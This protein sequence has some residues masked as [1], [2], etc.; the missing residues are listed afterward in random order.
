[1]EDS[2]VL[3]R[4]KR[5]REEDE[6]NL[7]ISTTE[8]ES[9]PKKQKKSDSSENNIQSSLYLESIVTKENNNNIH[10]NP[11]FIGE[12]K[13]TSNSPQDPKAKNSKQRKHIEIKKEEEV[14][15]F[16]GG[17]DGGFA[18]G[19]Q[20]LMDRIQKNKN[21]QEEPRKKKN[22]KI[23]SIG[24]AEDGEDLASHCSQG[25]NHDV[26]DILQRWDSLVSK[27]QWPMFEEMVKELVDKKVESEA[28]FSKA[29][30]SLQR[31]F[32]LLPKKAQL[33]HV[34][35]FMEQNG[36][37]PKNSQ[38][39]KLLI[40]KSGKSHSGVLVITVLTSPYPKVGDTVQ[41]FSCQW[42][43]YYCP[44]EPAHE[45]NNWTRQ[46]RSYLHDEPSVLRANRN[47]F[48]PVLQ[49]YD[50]AATLAMNGHPVD[51]IELLI[52]GGTW[53][54][55]PHQ[56]QEE[57]IRDL[58]YSAN[59]F[60]TREKR[61]K[62]SLDQEKKLNESA[63]CKIIGITLETRPDTITLEE[64]KR[65]RRYGCTR[66]QLGIQHTD[67][68]ILKKINRGCTL[69]DAIRAIRLLKNNCYKID[70]HLM[71]NLP[72]SSPE[73]DLEMFNYIL[74]SEDLQVDQ[75]KIYPC[76]ITPWT[77][78][79]KWYQSG[80]YV[81]YSD[82][83]L[84][85]LLLKVKKKVHPWIRLNRVIRDIP[86]QYILGGIDAP[87]LRQYL[88]ETLKKQGTPCRCI[89]CREVR[90]KEVTQVEMFVRT[91]HSSNGIEHFISFE[92]P[93]ETTIL[94]FLRLRFCKN[95]D[96]DTF[97]ELR[98]AALIRELHVYG[99]L[100]P[101]K[102]QQDSHAQHVG[103]GKRLMEKAETMAKENGCEKIAVIAGVGV[104]NYYRKLGYE[105]YGE[106]EFLIKKFK[107]PSKPPELSSKTFQLVEI[108]FFI[109][110]LFIFLASFLVLY[111]FS[112]SYLF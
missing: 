28:Q 39:R 30:L 25:Y 42:N 3:E 48:D 43:C 69:E 20:S 26:E 47:Y 71:P 73:K 86:S 14:I 19:T 50:R 17:G 15:K 70:I 57:F 74:D 80:K 99:K 90:L 66:I 40:K 31:K 24:I 49:F 98:N 9:L 105:M 101:T 5:K 63:V 108:H 7:N 37:I 22:P 95:D 79:E 102:D 78:I 6:I 82:E 72:Y 93:D 64:I 94:G 44:D 60:Y 29:L 104:R 83:E 34:F 58:F 13:E 68:Y 55:Y 91:Y 56:Y 53:A 52:L 92:T 75:W 32:K 62:L 46:P 109:L 106:G 59:T 51:K 84:I 61:P 97:P 88:I 36:S 45:G 81:P 2:M 10:V 67:N 11:I 111:S 65:F 100:I 41:T 38:L 12:K 87:N 76:E 96:Q 103:L 16:N 77:V 110:F 1:M 21:K 85:S 8:G 89:R 33:L 18:D 107:N 54:S 35:N 23:H 27:E 4:E 112:S